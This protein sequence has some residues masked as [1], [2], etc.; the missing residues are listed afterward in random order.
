MDIRGDSSNTDAL[1]HSATVP[2]LERALI[3]NI[4]CLLLAFTNFKYFQVPT[5]QT[6]CASFIWYF[7]NHEIKKVNGLPWVTKLN[8]VIR[9]GV[10]PRYTRVIGCLLQSHLG[11]FNWAF[12]DAIWLGINLWKK[13][14]NRWVILSTDLTQS[15]AIETFDIFSEAV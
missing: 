9:R 10:I 8:V 4:K 5:W 15:D 2:R 14:T 6:L 3:Y 12:K 11:I 1:T 7:I 13:I